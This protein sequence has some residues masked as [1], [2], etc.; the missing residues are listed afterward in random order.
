MNSKAVYV[1]AH[2][3]HDDSMRAAT[4]NGEDV[5]GI[6][7]AERAVAND[8]GWITVEAGGTEYPVAG[9]I[10]YVSGLTETC[11]PIGVTA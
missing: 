5:P 3:P 2:Y 1:M 6:L 8:G 11:S 10:A 9:W 4:L 7:R